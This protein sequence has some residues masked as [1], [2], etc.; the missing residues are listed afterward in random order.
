MCLH[1]QCFVADRR[2]D[3]VQERPP[4]QMFLMRLHPQC[5]HRAHSGK[6]G[7]A[8]NSCKRLLGCVIE[9]VIISRAVSDTFGLVVVPSMACNMSCFYCFEN[10][11]DRTEL[12]GTQIQSLLR[13]VREKLSDDNELKHLHV[14]G[15]GGEPL[16]N[17]RL[18]EY[19]MSELSGVR[20][21]PGRHASGD[22]VTNG[23]DLTQSVAQRQNRVGGNS[24]RTLPSM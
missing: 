7:R 22:L 6:A 1:Q 23:F 17:A 3:G 21:T 14:R 19:V 15:F 9:R 11:S 13:Y 5:P 24:T 20:R 18:I 4:A 8:E 12:D 10:K 2:L 16:R